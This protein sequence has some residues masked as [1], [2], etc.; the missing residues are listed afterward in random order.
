[1]PT[2]AL[3]KRNIK[4]V[5]PPAPRSRSLPLLIVLIIVAVLGVCLIALPASMLQR[6]LPTVLHAEDFSGTLWHGSAGR[7]LINEQ[8]AG[9]IEWHI[10][11]WSLL[12][13]T[14]AA[15]VRWVKIGFVANANV[16][17]ERHGATARNVVGQGRIEDL[18]DLGVAAGW[19]GGARFDFS[20]VKVN[21][22]ENSDAA[23]AIGLLALI[24]DVSVAELTSA[25]V[26][27]GTDLGGY[28]LHL[29]NG[30]ITPDA[31]ISAELAD[32]GGPLEVRATLHFSPKERVGTL[33]GTV[34]ERAQAGAALRSQLETLTQMHPRDV[35]GRIPVE[36]EFSL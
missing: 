3:P 19:H 4:T 1:M 14:I 7:L 18:A 15:D 30:A 33:V 6:A 27:A 20:E 10:H 8:N 35:R 34:K 21:F 17:I 29:S 26:A 28:A 32:T 23:H 25:A 5:T 31:E 12:S 36:L 22:A 9:A 24:G 13:L 11:P 2:S 16:L